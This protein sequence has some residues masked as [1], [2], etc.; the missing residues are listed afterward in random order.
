MSASGRVELRT[1]EERLAALLVGIYYVQ[2][3]LDRREFVEQRSKAL[4]DAIATERRDIELD[5]RKF[6]DECLQWI[7]DAPGEGDGICPEHES[8]G[9]RCER[10]EGHPPPC[11]CPKALARYD[12]MRK[13]RGQ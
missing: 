10:E 8:G 5:W 7:D 4:Q 9:V 12:K 11:A 2:A 1:R 6:A 3:D 13:E